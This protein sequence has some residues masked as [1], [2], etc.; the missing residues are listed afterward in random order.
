VKLSGELLG[1][2]AGS[3]HAVP[4]LE[5]GYYLLHSE[6]RGTAHCS[7]VNVLKN[8]GDSGRTYEVHN[9][10]QQ[11]LRGKV[12]LQW[13]GVSVSSRVFWK[14]ASAAADK[15]GAVIFN[16]DKPMSPTSDVLLD[17]QAGAA[18]VD[19]VSPLAG[20]EDSDDSSAGTAQTIWK[21]V[22]LKVSAK[23]F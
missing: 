23:H 10:K 15:R 9:F 2:L 1:D 8:K 14:A 3:M 18:F 12:Q 19:D 20:L 21:K 16:I 7:L 4:R 6:P 22:S 5:T 13:H 17:L 11:M